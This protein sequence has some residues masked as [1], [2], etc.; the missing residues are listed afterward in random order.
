MK[1]KPLKKELTAQFYRKNRLNFG[2]ALLGALL[3]GSLNLIVSWIMQQLIDVASGAEGTPG[4]EKLAW[5]S[6]GFLVFCAAVMLL[7]CFSERAFGGRNDG[8]ARRKDRA[9]GHERPAGAKGL[10]LRPVHRGAIA[11]VAA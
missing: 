4:F 8:G 3:S 5:I 2:I 9:R 1:H 10:L 6:G 11:A 7:T